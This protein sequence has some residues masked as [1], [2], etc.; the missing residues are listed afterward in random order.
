MVRILRHAGLGATNKANWF[1]LKTS[2]VPGSVEVGG[3]SE[4]SKLN[5]IGGLMTANIQWKL[6][7]QELMVLTPVH[8]Q[9]L[10]DLSCIIKLYTSSSGL[11]MAH[12]L[13]RESVSQT[14]RGLKSQ[15]GA[16][17]VQNDLLYYVA[18]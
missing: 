12:A 9:Q 5:F 4:M 1:H 15:I 7:L 18:V 17:S 8:L 6:Y 11:C 14:N 3:S 16:V 10:L 13:D 2:L